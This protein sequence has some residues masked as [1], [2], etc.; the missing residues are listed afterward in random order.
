MFTLGVDS[1]TS[2]SSD[3]RYIVM[4]FFL[5]PVTLAYWLFDLWLFCFAFWLIWPMDNSANT[6]GLHCHHCWHWPSL[7]SDTVFIQHSSWQG[8]CQW[9]HMWLIYWYTSPI[10]AQWVIWACDIYVAFEGFIY[11]WHIFYSSI[12]N[13][14]CSHWFLMDFCDNVGP[15]CRLQ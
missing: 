3:T 8:F 14:Y 10:N 1:I 12:V 4:L 6:I 2:P 13:K 11:C 7:L 9:V 5:F 15:I